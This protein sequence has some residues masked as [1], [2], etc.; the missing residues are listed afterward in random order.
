MVD[1]TSHLDHILYHAL[2]LNVARLHLCHHGIQHRH[3]LLERFILPL[4]IEEHLLVTELKH[5]RLCPGVATRTFHQ[6]P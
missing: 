3:V 2:E 5:I 1:A 6:L 4:H